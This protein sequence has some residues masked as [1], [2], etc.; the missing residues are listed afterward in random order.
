MNLYHYTTGHKLA[1]IAAAGRLMPSA[2]RPWAKHERGILW[3]SSNPVYEPSACKPMLT[4]QGDRVFDIAVL[5]AK[6]GLYR[7]AAP[8][9]DPA[10]LLPRLSHWPAC[11]IDANM[12]EADRV[13]LARA[14]LQMGAQPSHWWGALDPCPL[15]AVRLEVLNTDTGGW[16]PVTMAEA[17]E[18]FA[19]RGMVVASYS[20]HQE[21]VTGV[22]A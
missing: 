7:F 5:E 14:G 16:Q 3:F 2:I 17:L 15:A 6:V 9:A 12:R 22:A 18:Q 11:G 1:A 21:A 10:C 20:L 19:A 4:P 13:R 8:A